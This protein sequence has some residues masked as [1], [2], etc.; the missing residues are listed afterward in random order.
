MPISR[1]IPDVPRPENTVVIAYG[2]GKKRY[3]VRQRIGC[4]NVGGRYLPV[5]GS[6]DR[7]HC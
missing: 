3:I 1:E 4:R 2:S 6:Y 7:P 5:N